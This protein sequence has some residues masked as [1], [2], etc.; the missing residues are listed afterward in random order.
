MPVGGIFGQL[1][2]C[3]AGEGARAAG[4]R[5]APGAV[6]RAEGVTEGGYRATGNNGPH[7]NQEVPHLHAH[8]VGGR[9]KSARAPPP[10]AAKRRRLVLARHCRGALGPAGSCRSVA[11][12]TRPA[13][14]RCPP[15][16]RPRRP[17]R[18]QA[19]RKFRRLASGPGHSESSQAAEGSGVAGVTRAAHRR[20]G[21]HRLCAHAG[22]ALPG[23]RGGRY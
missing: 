21:G 9:P 19:A 17:R 16:G 20:A 1:A 12:G 22:A 11:G 10:L 23:C 14:R 3:A 7:G 8:L 18:S 2:H 13:H 6:A 4:I 5:R 15:R